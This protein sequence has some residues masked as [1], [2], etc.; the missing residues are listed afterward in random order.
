MSG[1]V[2]LRP[3]Q[4]IFKLLHCLFGPQCGAALGCTFCLRALKSSSSQGP[5]CSLLKAGMDWL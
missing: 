1:A 5:H 2:K 4:P 3:R